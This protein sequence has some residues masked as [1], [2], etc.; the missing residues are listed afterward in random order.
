M[1]YHFIFVTSDFDDT[2]LYRQPLEEEAGLSQPGLLPPYTRYLEEP[3]FLLK[4]TMA[5]QVLNRWDELSCR[6]N[7]NF[8]RS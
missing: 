7:S 8:C 1:I 6:Q 4:A 3:T 2:M 5:D